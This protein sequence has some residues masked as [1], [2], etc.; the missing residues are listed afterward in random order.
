MAKIKSILS[1]LFTSGSN[2]SDKKSIS[3]IIKNNTRTMILIFGIVSIVVSVFVAFFTLNSVL[4][5]SVKKR[6]TVP[7]Q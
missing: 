4:T 3:Q 2:G 7:Q 6:L 1:R 5:D